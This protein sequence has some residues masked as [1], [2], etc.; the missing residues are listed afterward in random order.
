VAAGART[1]EDAFLA[2]MDAE[3][4]PFMGDLTAFERLGALDGL[5]RDNGA[6][7]LTADGEAVLAG[8]ADRVEL[9]GFDRWIGGLH[10]RSGGDLWRWDAQR[11]APTR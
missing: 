4:A 9:I 1:R 5:V 2:A 11:G 7:A 10:V 6:L 8:R 3:E